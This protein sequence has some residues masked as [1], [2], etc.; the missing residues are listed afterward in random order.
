M[1]INAWACVLNRCT[2]AV[3]G[4][5]PDPLL[6]KQ[7]PLGG[8]CAQTERRGVMDEIWFEC[9]L[10][11]EMYRICLHCPNIQGLVMHQ[12]WCICKDFSVYHYGLSWCHLD[13]INKTQPHCCS[14]L[15][16]LCTIENNGLICLPQLLGWSTAGVSV[17]SVGILKKIN[18]R[19]WGNHFLLLLLLLL[20]SISWSRDEDLMIDL[21]LNKW[22]CIRG[23]DKD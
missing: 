12:F 23:G 13:N 8:S 22:W 21:C 7:R 1:V 18:L 16:T 2:C 5:W 19:C 14:S 9:A 4:F 3:P 11:W 17:C 10:K 15:W 20:F 6:C